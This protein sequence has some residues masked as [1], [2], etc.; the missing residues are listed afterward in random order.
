MLAKC[1][2]LCVLLPMVAAALVCASLGASS[3]VYWYAVI[4]AG[5]WGCPFAAGLYQRWQHKP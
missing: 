1:V 4:S 2:I 3:S 5:L